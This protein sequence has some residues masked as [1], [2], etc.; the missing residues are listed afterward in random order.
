MIK[1]GNLFFAGLTSGAIY[2]VFALCLTTLF[3]V[4]NI[5]NLAVGD[6]AML[7]ALGVDFFVRVDG[8]NTAA[9]IALVLTCIAM[10]A[11][12]YD[13]VVLRTALEGKRAQDAVL[14][15]FFFTFALSFFI[16]GVGEH[17]FGTDVH[18]APALWAGPA[19]SFAGLNIQRS[20]VLVVAF[21]AL[22]GIGFAAYMHF[23]LNGKAMAA[24]GENALGALVVGIKQRSYRRGMFVAMG[25]L[26]GIFGIIESPIT[27]YIPTTGGALGLTG[28]IA[29]AFAGFTRPGRAVI[30]GLVI[31]LVEAMLGGYVSS[32]YQDTL[33]YGFL[34]VLILYRPQLLGAANPA[35]AAT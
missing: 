23:S 21:A 13:W 24:C 5:L 35:G 16:E 20:G 32:Q 33:L 10:F 27:G 9:S 19:L 7:G 3:R 18:S 11:Y 12:L 29:A 25:V 26:A 14:V 34:I 1:F 31:G 6:F 17:A 2:A 30:A 22:T 8:W 28:V 15:V 4:S